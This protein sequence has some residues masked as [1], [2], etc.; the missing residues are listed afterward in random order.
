[1]RNERFKDDNGDWW[2]TNTQDVTKKL[3]FNLDTNQPYKN[4]ERILE[5][6]FEG[7]IFTQYRYDRPLS[8]YDKEYWGIKTRLVA[9]ELPRDA[10]GYKIPTPAV[11]SFSGGRTSAFMLKQI[12]NAHGGKLP[13]DIKVCFANTGKEL[14]ETLDFVHEVETMWDVDIHWLELQINDETPIWSQK[15]VTYETA[16]R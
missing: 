3:L 10:P 13:E 9:K 16:S 14:P 5:G 4:G 15:E 7:K 11:I 8:M 12:I 2:Y 1:M 6:K